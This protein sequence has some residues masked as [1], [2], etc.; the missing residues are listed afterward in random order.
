MYIEQ[1]QSFRNG[2]NFIR[3]QSQYA[4]SRRRNE[5]NLLDK[6]GQCTRC[7]ICESIFHWTTACPHK[8]VGAGEIHHHVTLFQSNH[9]NFFILFPRYVII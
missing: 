7:A 2:R 6:H 1:L 9:S 8:E 4:Q 5:M 3:S